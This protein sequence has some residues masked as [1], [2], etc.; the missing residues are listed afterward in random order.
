MFDA[1]REGEELSLDLD[2]GLADIRDSTAVPLIADSEEPPEV[3][4][5]QG[6]HRG[7][8]IGSR[9]CG[10]PGLQFN[11]EESEININYN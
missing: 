6:W 9:L 11:P 10:L 7:C 3:L 4:S 5:S 1:I 2:G 8:V